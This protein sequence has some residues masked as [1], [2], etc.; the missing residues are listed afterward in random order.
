[1]QCDVVDMDVCH[2]FLGIPWLF[3]WKLLH[4]G[5]ENSYEFVQNKQCYKL[6]PMREDGESCSKDVYSCNNIIVLCSA[7]EFLKE[8]K[9]SGC[10]LD[11]FPLKVQKVEIE[12]TIPIEIHW[13]LEEFKEIVAEELPA[14]LP[15]LHRISHQIDLILG[16]S[17]PIKAP[18]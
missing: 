18:H 9:K 8:Q 10:C 7:K 1:M 11:I 12:G 16:S 14:G 4:D 5:R 3:N 13:M 17:L 6:T 2:I 15:P